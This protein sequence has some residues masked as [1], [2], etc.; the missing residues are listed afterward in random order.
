M[1]G[2]YI[3]RLPE[4]LPSKSNFN[5]MLENALKNIKN[6]L[7]I[8]NFNEKVKDVIEK[9]MDFKPNVLD[10]LE[11]ICTPFQ[12]SE[13]YESWLRI[14]PIEIYSTN[15]VLKNDSFWA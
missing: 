5:L 2:E 13:A 9:S 14:T 8:F 4:P 6:C 12:M 10:A 15:A 1:S 3:I 7:R 11:K